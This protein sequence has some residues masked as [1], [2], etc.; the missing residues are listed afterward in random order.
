[1]KAKY[2]LIKRN[3][4]G[5][6][7][8]AVDSIT[9]KRE[10]LKTGDK[11]VALQILNAKNQSALQSGI[12]LQIARAYLLASDPGTATRVWQRVM[13]EMA[14]L[15]AGATRARWERAMRETPFDLIRSRPLIETRSENFLAVLQAGTISTNVFLRRLHNFALD[16]NWLPI[17]VLPRKQWPS[18]RFGEKRAITAEEAEA[19]LNIESNPERRSFYRLLWHLG[20]SQSDVANLAAED[21]DW[22]NRLISFQRMKSGTLVKLHFGDQI[23]GLLKTLPSKGPLFPK[24]SNSTE[25]DRAKQF[26]RSCRRL[27]LS[28]IT[29]HSYRYAWAERAKQAGYPERFAQEALGHASNAVHRAYSKKAQMRLPS[30]EDYERRGLLAKSSEK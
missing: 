28:G 17:P 4:R 24:L 12:N 23:A 27:R 18:V 13:D 11:S 2:R 8:Y 3:H 5:G 16:M 20:G 29:L 21:V 1:M 19:I 9:G 10:S 6:T 7:Y 26:W 14:R 25:S 30:L 22:E 15:K